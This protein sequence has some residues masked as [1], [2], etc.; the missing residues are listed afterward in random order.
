MINA[1]KLLVKTA[2]KMRTIESSSNPRIQKARKVLL[3]RDPDHFLIEGSKLFEEAIRSG[4]QIEE[5]YLTQEALLANGNLMQEL[6]TKKVPVNRISSRLAK[7]ISDVDT[8]PGLTAIL[9][10]PG[11][12]KSI[13]G[14]W[15]FFCR[16]CGILEMWERSSGRRKGRDV[17]QCFIMIAQIHSSQKWFAHRWEAFSASL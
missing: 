16:V 3:R 9:R 4:M 6:E 5:A 12:P 8:P 14:V 2:G 11:P 7:L 1:A 13:S 17:M 15:E 10:K